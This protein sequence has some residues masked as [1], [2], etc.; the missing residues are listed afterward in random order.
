LFIDIFLQPTLGN[1]RGTRNPRQ[2]DSFQ[3]QAINK[4]A[5]LVIDSVVTREVF[6]KV[7]ATILEAIVLLVI[8][9]NAIFNDIN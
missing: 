7:A 8:V 3:E 9:S 4:A 6:Y 2:G 1:L 5:C